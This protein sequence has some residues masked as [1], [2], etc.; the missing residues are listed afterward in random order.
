MSSYN[1]VCLF[2]MIV[3]ISFLILVAMVTIL[4][5]KYG[6][7]SYQHTYIYK[8]EKCHLLVIATVIICISTELAEYQ[9]CFYIETIWSVN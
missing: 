3:W 4:A 7:L 5:G 8:M 6:L 2:T 9:H 1:L